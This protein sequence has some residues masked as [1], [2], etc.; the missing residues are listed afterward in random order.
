MGLG[1]IRPVRQHLPH[2]CAIAAL[3]IVIERDYQD[4]YDRA[5][6]LY[7]LL[8]AGL[9]TAQ[10]Q[11]IARM[12][13][14]PLRVHRGPV[15]FDE[16]EGVLDIEASHPYFCHAVVLF[17]GS[18]Y[19]PMDGCFYDPGTYLAAYPASRKVRWGRLLVR[20]RDL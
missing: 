19:D 20:V 15:E 2:T 13:Q 7:P 5:E 8:T 6:R 17:N 10:I 12:F 4:V 3:S 16:D 14:C 11:R 18:I 1:V 9:T